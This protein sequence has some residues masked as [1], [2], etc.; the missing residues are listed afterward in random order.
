MLLLIRCVSLCF[1]CVRLSVCVCVCAR[2]CVRTY[3]CLHVWVH[4][5]PPALLGDLWELVR[6]LDEAT[7][8][9][10]HEIKRVRCLYVYT[11]VPLSVCLFV[12]ARVCVCVIVCPCVFVCVCVCWCV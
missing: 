1:A 6:P 11:R 4:G 2:V 9:S 3:V 8:R 10:G 5:V 12:F 7:R